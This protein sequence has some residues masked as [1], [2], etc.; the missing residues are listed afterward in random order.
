MA[1]INIPRGP[2]HTPP[3]HAIKPG[4]G[5]TQQDADRIALMQELAGVELGTEDLAI[6]DWTV[7]IWESSTVATICSWLRRVREAPDA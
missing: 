2:I 3:Y 6:I 5:E 7:D 4:D 1:E